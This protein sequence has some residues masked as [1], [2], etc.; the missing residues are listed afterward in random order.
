MA[1]HESLPVLAGTLRRK[2]RVVAGKGATC[3]H[4][5]VHEAQKEH[6]R[7]FQPQ[8]PE[9]RGFSS[10]PLQVSGLGEC[11]SRCLPFSAMGRAVKLILAS[12]M[13]TQESREGSG[14]DHPQELR[15][16]LVPFS[17]SLQISLEVKT[18]TAVFPLQTMSQTGFSTRCYQ[19]LLRREKSASSGWLPPRKPF[20]LFIS[21]QDCP[22]D[23]YV[24]VLR[25]GCMLRGIKLG[26]KHFV[27]SPN[28]IG[29]HAQ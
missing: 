28:W 19:W 2:S 11:S 12:N 5:L 13:A 25:L 15:G 22:T 18:G 9:V 7:S 24:K 26:Q 4:E 10:K 14:C 1:L 16:W 20:A 8:S 27:L 29:K 23:C 21:T 6:P 17:S 3:V